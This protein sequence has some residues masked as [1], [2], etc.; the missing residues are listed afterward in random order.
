MANK[1]KLLPLGMVNYLILI[2]A[3]L[4]L[5]IGYLIMASNEIVFSP[6]IVVAGY[7][8]IVPFGL[9]YKGKRRD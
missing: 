3:A 5:I 8:L 6:L 7:V 1:P 2:G 9:L 4:L